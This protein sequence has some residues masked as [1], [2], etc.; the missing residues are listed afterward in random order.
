[1]AVIDGVKTAFSTQRFP[2]VRY[3]TATEVT[4]TTSAETADTVYRIVST[5]D[6]RIAVGISATVTASTGTLL[7]AGAIEYILVG[8]GENIAVNGGTLNATEIS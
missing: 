1:M 5:A 2:V 3:G 7:P 4:G 8:V 6:I